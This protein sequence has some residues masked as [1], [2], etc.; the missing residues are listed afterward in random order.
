MNLT[1][2]FTRRLTYLILIKSFLTFYAFLLSFQILKI[3][4]N[5]QFTASLTLLVLKC[6]TNQKIYRIKNIIIN[7]NTNIVKFITNF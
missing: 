7:N 2:W 3:T 5:T 1:A 4:N 6:S